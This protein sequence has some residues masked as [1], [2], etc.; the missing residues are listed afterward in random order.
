VQQMQKMLGD[1]VAARFHLDTAA[2]TREVVPVEQHRRQTSQQYIGNV[3]RA[4]FIVIRSFRPHAA[5]HGDAGAQCVHGMRRAGNQFQRLLDGGG[6]SAQAAQASAIRGKLR[7]VGEFAVDEE[8][9]DLFKLA[10]RGQ[11]GNVVAAIVQVVAA[12]AYRA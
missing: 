11:V 3:A 8:I 12:L 4:C 9:R 5:E 10:V 7:L 2:M 6:Q 1:A